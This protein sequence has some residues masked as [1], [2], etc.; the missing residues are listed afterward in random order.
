MEVGKLIGQLGYINGLINAHFIDN[1]T[2]NA[3][4]SLVSTL[5][6]NVFGETRSENGATNTDYRYTGQ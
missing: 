2:V 3:N 1:S 6:D 4:G 5:L